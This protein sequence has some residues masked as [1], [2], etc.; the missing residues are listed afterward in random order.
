MARLLPKREPRKEPLVLVLVLLPPG[1]FPAP[2]LS[3]LLETPP[4][5]VPAVVCCCPGPPPTPVPGLRMG[6]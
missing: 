3:T 1:L 2:G 6:R 4:T 5:P